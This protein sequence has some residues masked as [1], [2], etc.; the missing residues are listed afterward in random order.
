[1]DLEALWPFLLGDGV[2]QTPAV[3]SMELANEFDFSSML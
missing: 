2:M 1:L 3:G